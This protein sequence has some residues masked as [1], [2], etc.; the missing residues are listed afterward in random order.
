[1]LRRWH[2][3]LAACVAWIASLSATEH[4]I[5]VDGSK[6]I[7]ENWIGNGVQWAAYPHC[8]TA[9]EAKGFTYGPLS[10][11]QFERVLARLDVMQPQ[12]MR[13]M[14]I[15]CWRYFEGFD[16][17]GEPIVDYENE[18]M[19]F[20]YRCLDYCQSRG[21]T[22]LFGEWGPRLGKSS[23]KSAGSW[24]SL[25]AYDER[26]MDMIADM[27]HHLI[28]VKGYDCIRYYD[29][30][31]EPYLSWSYS[32]GDFKKYTRGMRLLHEALERR[33][34]RD[35]ILLNCSWGSGWPATTLKPEQVRSIAPYADIYDEHHYMGQ[36]AAL[37]TDWSK[38][39]RKHSNMIRK[40]DREAPGFFVGETNFK[41]KEERL[42]P[43]KEFCYNGKSIPNT[44]K[45]STTAVFEWENGVDMAVN[46]I[47]K[48]RGGLLG[49][50]AWQFDDA[51]HT[52]DDSGRDLKRW[53]FFDSMGETYS[54]RSDLEELRP[55][56]YTWTLMCRSFPQGM[57]ILDTENGLGD[58]ISA[59]A[60]R[61]GDRW[62]VALVNVSDAARTVQID[63]CNG[64]SYVDFKQYNYFR[65]QIL[66]D[67]EGQPL[68]VL[69]KQGIDL[70]D[71]MQLS[72]HGKGFIL[73][74][75]LELS[76]SR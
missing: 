37:R 31:N 54:D 51:M 36:K 22:V 4:I 71:G 34:I 38:R 25:P 39:I 70:A 60:G 14:I 44:G 64:P 56:F 9:N 28:V 55:W 5:T 49:T 16:S 45:D 63:W 76:P 48:M 65:D 35:R 29:F 26:W 43:L 23:G 7:T 52:Q 21:I 58:G 72:F 24:M 19:Q 61:M 40:N 12:F 32:A 17:A 73:L 3:L 50:I 74:D 62:V 6:I 15:G 8:D 47:Q 66:S 42:N 11:A 1:M 67:A 10:D 68:P 30:E 46:A 69:E 20:L 13:F 41:P 33:G 2:G 53:G 27:L 75:L 59:V 57:Q 18:E